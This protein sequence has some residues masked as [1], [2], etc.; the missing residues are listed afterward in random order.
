M[1]QVLTSQSRHGEKSLG[2]PHFD[3]KGNSKASG[4][5][6][7]FTMAATTGRWFSFDIRAESISDSRQRCQS[8]PAKSF[9]ARTTSGH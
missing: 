4:K 9:T 7:N 5:S 3:A 8:H 1:V 2:H 6:K